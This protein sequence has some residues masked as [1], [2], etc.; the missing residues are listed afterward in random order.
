VR[1]PNADVILTPIPSG[2][3]DEQAVFVGDVFSTGYHAAFEGRVET[4]DTVVIFGCGPI[5]LGALVSAWQFGPRQVL[6]VDMLDNRLALAD[7]YGATAIH[8]GRDQVLEQIQEVTSGQGADVAIE[9]AGSPDAFAQ[10]LKAVRRGG[11]VSVV[12]LFPNEVPLPIHELVYYGV[13]I[14]MGLGNLSRMDK[15][16]GLVETGRVDLA[17]L[18]TH[19]FALEEAM[20]AYDLFENHK[21]Q[22]VKVLLKP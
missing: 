22:C 5:G 20:E 6:A 3:P 7:H 4:G 1:V 12:G 14:S 18:A 17:P 11:R 19:T 15:L 21:D 10:A 13:Q 16:M 8:A 2:V 9:A